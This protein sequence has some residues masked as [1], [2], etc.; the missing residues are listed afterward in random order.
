MAMW[1]NAW[2]I[3]SKWENKNLNLHF[4]KMNQSIKAHNFEEYENNVLS[5]LVNLVYHRYT[6]ISANKCGI[7][8]NLFFYSS[9]LFGYNFWKWDHKCFLNL[10]KDI[11]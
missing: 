10:L 2:M 1:K 4:I 3:Y 5:C 7:H 8:D 11:S 6:V 9:Y